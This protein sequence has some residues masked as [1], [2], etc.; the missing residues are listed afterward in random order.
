MSDENL[1]VPERWTRTRPAA[2][3]WFAAACALSGC[4]G[5]GDVAPEAA[6]LGA[7]AGA[8]VLTANPVVG[9][10]VA[11]GVR[12]ATAEGIGYV[13]NEQRRQ[14]QRAITAAAS[15]AADS[16]AVRWSTNPDAFYRAVFGTV[17]GHVQ[18]VRDFGGRIRCREILYTVE[19]D[20]GGVEELVDDPGAE[21]QSVDA[22]VLNADGTSPAE[23]PEPTSG[24]WLEASSGPVLAAVICRGSLGWQWPVSEPA[25][26]DR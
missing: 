21:V 24:D 7:G 2:I 4:A 13:K 3:P 26:E 8:G 6:G 22:A 12:L 15:D 1:R 19:D 5:F 11:L 9:V 25:A 10:A 20:G 14:V 17:R 23:K 16:V 18:A